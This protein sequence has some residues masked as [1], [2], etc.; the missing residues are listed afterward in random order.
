MSKLAKM[1]DHL[2]N[3]TEKI[4]TEAKH[5]TFMNKVEASDVIPVKKFVDGKIITVLYDR[6]NNSYKEDVVFSEENTK[7]KE[8]EVIKVE[9]QVDE[10]TKNTLATMA[11]ELKELKE[12]NAK[13]DAQIK[14]ANTKP[15]AKAEEVKAEDN[16][17]PED[18]KNAE[19]KKNTQEVKGAK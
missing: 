3:Q 18:N 13:L 19:D 14:E 16:K 15:E 10:E 8:T 9:G 12:A 4:D 5:K 2:P 7:T 11:K 6:K 17:K 1:E